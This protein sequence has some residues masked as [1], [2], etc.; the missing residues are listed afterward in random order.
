LPRDP[1]APGLVGWVGGLPWRGHDLGILKQGIAQ[2]LKDNNLR[3]YHGGHINDPN[4]P[5]AAQQLEM[6]SAMVETRPLCGMAGVPDLWAPISI[7]VIPLEDTAFNRSKSYVKGLEA[8][9][10]GLPFIAS[11]LPEYEELGVG[12]L[13]RNDRPQDWVDALLDLLEPETRILESKR[14]RARAEELSIQANWQVWDNVYREFV[15][16]SVAA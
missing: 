6:A 10:S 8:C 14:N 4:A 1:T 15:S 3:F 12:R 5:T 13:V 16:S 11:K 9:A 2:F 7:A